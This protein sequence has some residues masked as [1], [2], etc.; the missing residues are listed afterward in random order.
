MLDCRCTWTLGKRMSLLISRLA[1]H[2]SYHCVTLTLLT[3]PH[4]VYTLPYDCSPCVMLH[5]SVSKPSKYGQTPRMISEC[6][7]FTQSTSSRGRLYKHVATQFHGN[8][9]LADNLYSS[10]V[11]QISPQ[12]CIAIITGE[13]SSFTHTCK[14]CLVYNRDGVEKEYSL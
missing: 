2:T 11:Y 5:E 14:G 10:T 8:M 4:P 7:C 6:A 1:M 12:Q 3:S 9:L 13:I